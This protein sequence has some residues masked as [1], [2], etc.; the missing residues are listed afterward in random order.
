MSNNSTNSQITE[1][2]LKKLKNIKTASFAVWLSDEKRKEY[3]NKNIE[4]NLGNLK[5]NV[6]L[7]GLNPS[8]PK[9]NP[10]RELK[11]FYNFHD[12]S[13]ADIFLRESIS[14]CEALKG[15]YMTDISQ[16]EKGTENEVE[17]SDNDIEIFKEQLKIL[18]KK[19]YFVVC[20]GKKT[21]ENLLKDQTP[22]KE[23]NIETK[24]GKFG[25]YD[26]HCYKVLHYS[27]V[28]NYGTNPAKF[29]SE[30][31]A[32]NELISKYLAAHSQ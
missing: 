16:T 3:V 32:A 9:Y 30:L 4:E 15:A 27:K 24:S 25:D 18:G 21:F 31:E 29:I 28:I 8:E 22:K 23:N 12:G 11:P 7:L 20:F 14:K 5:N 2:K 19:E 26:L 17:I 6:I 1:E 10:S 13:D